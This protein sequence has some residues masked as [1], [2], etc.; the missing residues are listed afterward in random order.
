MGFCS[1][2]TSAG[3]RPSVLLQEVIRAA[4]S[5]V[6]HC[7]TASCPVENNLRQEV[8]HPLNA[9]F[10]SSA[11]AG[12]QV[13][14]I[15]NSGAGGGQHR[16]ALLDRFVLTVYPNICNSGR[17]HGLLFL[18]Y[19]FR[20]WHTG[21]TGGHS[22]QHRRALLCAKCITQLVAVPAGAAM[23][24]FSLSAASPK[25]YECPA[26]ARLRSL[27]QRLWTLPTNGGGTTPGRSALPRSGRQPLAF[28]HKRFLGV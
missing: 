17:T 15:R 6:A 20:C 11:T 19:V 22:R 18:Q 4:T 12:V 24:L 2:A 14:P 7:L 25:I 27:K 16:R 1:S 28:F 10:C 9:G 26:S 21:S 8:N 3:V 23:P 5:T 13:A